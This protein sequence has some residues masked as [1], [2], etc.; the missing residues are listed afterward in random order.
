MGHRAGEDQR[1]A[2]ARCGVHRM[3]HRR[4]VVVHDDAARVRDHLPDR[5]VD[6]VVG[7]LPYGVQHG[8]RAGAGRLQR[9]PGEVLDAALPRWVAV[10]RPGAGVA[11]AWNHRTLPRHEFGAL[12]ERAGLELVTPHDDRSFRH[13]VD[14]SI[15]RDVVVA[16]RR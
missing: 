15:T 9:R 5:S 6:L 1:A 16:R 3:K 10:L 4:V 13:R 8:S 2:V 14:R 11:L 7:D 12:L